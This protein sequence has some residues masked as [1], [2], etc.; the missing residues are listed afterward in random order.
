MY[1]SLLADKT[2]KVV[3]I[4]STLLF[5]GHLPEPSKDGV[6]LADVKIVSKLVQTCVKGIASRVLPKDNASTTL[7][8]APHE[9][10]AIGGHD[11]M[12]TLFLIMPSW[13]IPLSCWKALAPKM[14]LWGWQ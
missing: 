1:P 13:C 5:V 2:L 12:R 4:Q 9:P 8:I 3:I 7:G 6:Q 11:L 14:A 10:N